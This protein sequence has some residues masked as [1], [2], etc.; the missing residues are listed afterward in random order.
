MSENIGW[1]IVSDLYK[2]Q[3]FYDEVVRR[4]NGK[5]IRER[6][7]GQKAYAVECPRCHKTK[8]RMGV[9][10]DGDTYIFVCPRDGC[11]YYVNLND[12]IHDLGD[13]KL[14]SEWTKARMIT[15][16]DP[17][18]WKPRKNKKT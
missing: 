18:G 5:L 8:A 13:Q 14:K 3:P 6:F 17:Q 12:L 15:W 10:T 2:E 16:Y 11:N 9:S 7:R 1:K 4:L